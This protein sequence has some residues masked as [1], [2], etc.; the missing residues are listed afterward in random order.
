MLKKFK[1]EKLGGRVL[2]SDGQPVFGRG[3]EDV[4]QHIEWIKEEL[5]KARVPKNHT[6][7]EDSLSLND[8][9]KS[10]TNINV[11]FLKKSN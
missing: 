5:S 4:K 8:N 10:D 6:G 2:K 11:Y 3:V 1:S 9:I 7:E